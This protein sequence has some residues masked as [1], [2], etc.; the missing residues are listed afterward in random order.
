M[1]YCVEFRTTT[2][3]NC[4][5]RLYVI[6]YEIIRPLGMTGGDQDNKM[7]VEPTRVETK[8]VGGLPG[9]GINYTKMKGLHFVGRKRNQFT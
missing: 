2:D 1:R 9:T 7:N 3:D 8:L 5:V 4:P 6:V